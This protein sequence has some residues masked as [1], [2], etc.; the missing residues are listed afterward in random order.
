MRIVLVKTVQN[1]RE[2]GIVRVVTKV[3]IRHF[4]NPKPN[5]P[6]HLL[7]LVI[8]TILRFSLQLDFQKNLLEKKGKTGIVIARANATIP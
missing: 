6:L 7:S 2:H 5:R 8:P 1:H 4:L 3:V